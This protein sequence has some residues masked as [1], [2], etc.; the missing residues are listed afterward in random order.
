MS[1]KAWAEAF[2]LAALVLGY[3]AGFI[4]GLLFEKPRT[5]KPAKETI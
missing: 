1:M 2:I 5:E 3:V 4:T